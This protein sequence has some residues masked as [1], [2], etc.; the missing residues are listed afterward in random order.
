MSYKWSVCSIWMLLVE[1][2]LKLWKLIKVP[3]PLSQPLTRVTKLSWRRSTS[4]ATSTTTE[5]R[6]A[7]A[8]PL[9]KDR[10]AIQKLGIVITDKAD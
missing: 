7:T 8:I 2:L 3:V 5:T 9:V 4:A 10:D 6:G 1:I